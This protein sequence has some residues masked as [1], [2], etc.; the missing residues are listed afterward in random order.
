MNELESTKWID[1]STAYIHT[2]TVSHTNAYKKL[3]ETT[4][5]GTHKER[6]R[7]KTEGRTRI[8]LTHEIYTLLPSSDWDSDGRDEEEEEEGNG[9][10]TIMDHGLLGKTWDSPVSINHTLPFT[11]ERNTDVVTN[12]TFPVM[13]QPVTSQH[14]TVSNSPDA[15]TNDERR[16]TFQFHS[17]GSCRSLELPSRV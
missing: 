5:E 6:E 4:S 9:W 1:Q 11:R 7:K 10:W 12:T 8:L 15:F 3:M 13:I 17:Q 16:A 2:C 14:L